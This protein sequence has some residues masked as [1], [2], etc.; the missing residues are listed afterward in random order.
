MLIN[1]IEWSFALVWV[2]VMLRRCVCWEQQEDLSCRVSPP[3]PIRHNHDIAR[4]YCCEHRAV[5]LVH[6]LHWVV[7]ERTLMT[8]NSCRSAILCCACTHMRSL[9]ELVCTTTTT[10]T[11]SGTCHRFAWN[12]PPICTNPVTCLGQGRRNLPRR[13]L[14]G[15]ST[16]VFLRL[17]PTSWRFGSET[18]S[19]GWFLRISMPISVAACNAGMSCPCKP[20]RA[21]GFESRNLR[22]VILYARAPPESSPGNEFLYSTNVVKLS[23]TKFKPIFPGKSSWRLATK[24]LLQS[25]LSKF[26][27]SLPITSETT[28]T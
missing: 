24:N 28:F 14:S 4:S 21:R 19:A 7:F 9:W 17:W 16:I 25:S 3:S 10:T 23:V 22:Q 13:V 20:V 18:I 12:T 8:M 6:K 15:Y 2:D 11:L 26:N 27:I 1:A 5:C